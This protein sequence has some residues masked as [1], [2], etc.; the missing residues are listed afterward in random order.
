MGESF[1][2]SRGVKVNF[3]GITTLLDKLNAQFHLPEPPYYE[4]KT[5]TGAVEKHLHDETT[6]QTDEEKQALAGYQSECARL[7]AEQQARL[8]RLVLLRGITFE[9]PQ[10]D[11]WIKEQT[12][13]G[14]AVPDDPLERRLHYIETEVIAGVA[15]VEAVMLGV[16]AASGVPEDLLKQVEATFRHSL[17]QSN[18]H[19]TGGP[20]AGTDGQGLEP[21]PALRAHPGG[22]AVGDPP[23]RVRRSR[24]RR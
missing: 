13:L 19:E 8:T 10:S 22:D 5:A 15:D 11:D 16:L 18:G 23:Q 1:T 24:G 21:E 3:V 12:Y 17:G 2:T 7:N 9:Y 4:I 6:V 14:I 20:A